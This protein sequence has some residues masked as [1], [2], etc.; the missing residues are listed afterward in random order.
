VIR[1]LRE[2]P[3]FVDLPKWP[4]AWNPFE[5]FILALALASSYGL[6]HGQ[7]GSKVL[8]DRLNAEVVILWGACLAFGSALA[9]VGVWCYRRQERL[10]AGLWLESGG[11]VLVGLA[12]SIYGFVIL[13]AAHEFGDVRFSSCVTIAFAAACFMRAGQGYLA[14]WRTRRIYL[15]LQRMTRRSLEHPHGP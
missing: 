3:P 15:V 5:V 13:K 10:V 9:L 4:P 7:S 2:I 8:D 14:L 1:K 6:I 12:A 11:L